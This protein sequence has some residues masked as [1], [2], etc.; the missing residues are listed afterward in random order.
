[1]TKNKAESFT[2]DYLNIGIMGEK[3]G[4][5]KTMLAN[6]TSSVAL[7]MGASLA[8]SEVDQRRELGILYPTVTHSLS[9]ADVEA[10]Q[11]YDQAEIKALSPMFS[12]LI[13]QRT[14]LAVADIGANLDRRVLM[15][16]IQGGLT[17]RMAAAG[18]RMAIVI[19][20]FLE[21]T[22]VGAAARTARRAR[23]ALPDARI[24][25]CHCQ[26]NDTELSQAVKKSADWTEVIEP[27][28]AMHG[29]MTM[30][31]L[32]PSV[33]AAL[34]SSQKTPV[35]FIKMEEQELTAYCENDIFIASSIRAAMQVFVSTMTRQFVDLFRFRRI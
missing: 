18:R 25:F 32:Q 1:M 31:L 8:L 33:L 5:W 34:R 12:T 27:L 23:V 30:P 2:S 28:I 4:G 9:V 7:D 3:G 19:P 29:S 20:Y 16:M 10:L 17:E 21:P 35:D 11:G 24:I 13:E 26:K 22:S 15:A 14:T 6:T